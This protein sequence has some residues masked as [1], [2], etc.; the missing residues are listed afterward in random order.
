[1]RPTILGVK[2]AFFYG[3][4]SCAFFVAPYLNLFFLLLAFLT[5]VAALT[6]LWNVQNLAGVRGVVEEIAPVPVGV[7]GPVHVQLHTGHRTRLCIDVRLALG[8]STPIVVSLPTLRGDVSAAGRLPPLPRGVHTITAA[9]LESTHPLG[10]FRR[11]RALAAPA[12]VIVH[13]TPAALASARSRNEILAE[14]AGTPNLP[15]AGLEPTDL[16]D[17]R[18]GD[19]PRRISWKATAR[20][21]S[22]IVREYETPA[23]A[24]L[25]VVLDLRV[26]GD[27]LERA[28]SLA[29]ALAD[30]ARDGKEPFVLHTH[31]HSATYGDG[32]RPRRELLRYL[33]AARSVGADGPP[34]PAVSPDTL[35]LPGAHSLTAAA[36][37]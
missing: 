17:Y 31:D 35:R 14:L 28:L 33:A 34:P 24:A 16:R 30:L 29:V 7:G 18:A 3:V 21:G 36:T 23:T 9:W 10:L 32:H 37:R 4:L 27:E 22:L 20:R 5:V 8:D 26:D 11:R 15:A 12:E 2:A 6:A 25:E 1:M 13:S 19:E